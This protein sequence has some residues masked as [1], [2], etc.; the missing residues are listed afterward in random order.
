MDEQRKLFVVFYVD[1]VQGIY[2]QDDPE[3]SQP[4]IE[5]L[6]KVYELRNLDDIE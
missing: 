5:E 6:K 4:L 3:K 2:H 1:G